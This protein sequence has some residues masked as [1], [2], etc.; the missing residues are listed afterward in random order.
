M[1]KEP[2]NPIDLDNVFRA[3]QFHVDVQQRQNDN[4]AATVIAEAVN[5]IRSTAG[6][7][8][9]RNSVADMNNTL[10]PSSSKYESLVK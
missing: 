10:Q 8:L 9:L 4:D 3:K 5:T 6:N 7:A 2:P 1:I